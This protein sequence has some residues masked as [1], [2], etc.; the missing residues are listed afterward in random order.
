MRAY[1]QE[2]DAVGIELLG[3]DDKKRKDFSV[4]YKW[5]EEA[6]FLIVNAEGTL[7]HNKS[8]HL[9]EIA[10]RFPC[11]LM[12]GVWEAN[13][14]RP[15]TLNKFLLASVRESVSKKELEESDYTGEIYVTPDMVFAIDI[16][17]Y[18][19]KDCVVDQHP[20]RFTDSVFRKKWKGDILIDQHPEDYVRDLMACKSLVCGRF[21]GL[22]LAAMLEKPFSVYPSNTHKNKSILLDMDALQLYGESRKEAR[23]IVPDK[24]PE[25]VIKYK[26]EAP[27]KIRTM[28][29][30]LANLRI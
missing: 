21:H 7:H 14:Y 2:L 13:T 17:R 27:G 16:K 18:I 22:I 15:S 28:F 26:N 9:I 10:D 23:R 11:V 5:F 19:P 8:E 12:N 29:E 30:R 24:C 4:H 20:Y 25:S 1:E 6:D 3:T